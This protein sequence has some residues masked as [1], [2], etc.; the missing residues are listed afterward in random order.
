[1]KKYTTVS[2]DCIKSKFY[3]SYNSMESYAGKDDKDNSLV[4]A[5]LRQTRQTGLC[6]CTENHTGLENNE[7]NL[8]YVQCSLLTAP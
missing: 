4:L 8:T 1:M 2:N 5:Q 6:Q 3:A 7:L